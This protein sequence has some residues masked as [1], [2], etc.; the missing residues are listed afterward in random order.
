MKYSVPLKVNSSMSMAANRLHIHPNEGFDL[1]LM[2]THYD[3]ELDNVGPMEIWLL[4]ECPKQTLEL[5]S[6]IWEKMGK[7]G[8]VVLQMDE[9]KLKAQIV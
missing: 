1:G 9:G 2:T 5:N 8:K 6:K 3:I 7:P 4:N